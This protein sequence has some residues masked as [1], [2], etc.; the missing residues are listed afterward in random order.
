MFPSLVNCCT[1][2]W[3][4]EWPAEVPHTETISRFLPWILKASKMPPAVSAFCQALYS[5]GKQQ[6]TLEDLNLPNLEGT[7]KKCKLYGCPF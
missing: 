6:M 2:D 1:I 7:S 3:F 5:V 4:A